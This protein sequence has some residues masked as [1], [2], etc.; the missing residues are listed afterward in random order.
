M[1]FRFV[2]FVLSRLYFAYT[3]ILFVP[4]CTAIFFDTKSFFAF[5]ISTITVFF[6]GLFL[7][8]FGKRQH[9]HL[10][11]RDAIFIV[12]GGWLSLCLLGMLPY[13]FGMPNLSLATCFFESTSM[14]TTTGATTFS[15][16]KIL[17][18]SFMVWRTLGHWCGAVGVIMFFSLFLPAMQSGSDFILSA[19]LPG[20]GAERTM[21][22]L[23]ESIL[24]I[25]GIFIGINLLETLLLMCGGMNIWQALNM[26]MASAATGGLSFFQDG[27][28]TFSNNYLFAVCLIFMFLGGVNFTLWFKLWHKDWQG[29]KNDSE[30][31]YYFVFIFVAVIL[32]FLNLCFY[33]FGF[34]DSLQNALSMTL[35]CASTSGF[36]FC[37]F[38]SL[39]EFSKFVL[40][41]L[42]AVGGCS[43]SAAGGI[44]I[45]R[46]VVLFKIIKAELLTVL[47]PN[48]IYVTEYDGKIL[49][50]DTVMAVVKYFFLYVFMLAVFATAVS[51]SGINLGDSLAMIVSAL[52]SVGLG[53]DAL[54]NCE[55]DFAKFIAALAMLFGRLEFTTLLAILHF[56]FWRTK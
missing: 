7:N 56:D 34:Q 11:V 12:S 10:N 43:A 41:I 21:P 19:E 22:K 30:H 36:E 40:L 55:S 8:I 52:S 51:F 24:V 13:L 25:L 48:M 42:M 49:K 5:S 29:I 9:G 6:L 38:A 18:L 16:I 17:P 15:S 20:R 28:I 37:D 39:P 4:L 27:I 33:N 1:N 3:A 35:S 54:K 46:V 45:T 47:H 23:R 31:R 32:V 50:K 53:M 26:A 2:G 44:K 14:W